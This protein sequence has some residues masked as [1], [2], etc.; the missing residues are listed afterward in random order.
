[1]KVEY[2]GH[3]TCVVQMEGLNI[4]T[5]PFLR[6][7]L[8]IVKKRFSPLPDIAKLPK[9]DL[10]LQSHAHLD[11]LDIKSYELLPRDT[12]VVAAEN[13]APII[14]GL[15]F[16][17]VV[18]LTWGQEFRFR[19]FTITCTPVQHVGGR[20]FNRNTGYCSFTVEGERETLYFG[21]DTAYFPGFKK[22]GDAF[23]IDVALLPIGAYAPRRALKKLHMNPR[24]ALMAFRD[25]KARF[26][27]PIHWG[28]FIL[29]KEGLHR[30]REF[31]Q[32]LIVEEH[33]EDRIIILP[34][35]GRHDFPAQA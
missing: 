29:S 31:M 22:I 26:M 15:G 23:D 25:L 20:V 24:D 33:L 2:I 17:N 30:P 28:T 6:H 21:G 14:E 27:V 1:M 32:R 16:T 34:H 13:I 18:S 7:R 19:G 4:I 12:Q 11:H 5:D 35:L 9:F 3:A 10:V 8:A